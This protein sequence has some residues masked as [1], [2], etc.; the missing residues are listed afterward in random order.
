[1]IFLYKNN[2]WVWFI[3]IFLCFP[4]TWSEQEREKKGPGGGPVE[5]GSWPDQRSDS[6]IG[7]DE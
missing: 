5:E 7:G 2:A 3:L 6:K 4:W 1:M